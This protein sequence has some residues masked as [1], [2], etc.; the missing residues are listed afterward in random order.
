MKIKKKGL[1]TKGKF[2]AGLVVLIVLSVTSYFFYSDYQFKQKQA[3]LESI[4]FN[5]WV[6]KLPPWKYINP[7]K[8]ELGTPKENLAEI[9]RM[10]EM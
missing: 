5:K 6:N 8:D 1:S 2:T 7:E 4:R 3:R 10:L 9:E